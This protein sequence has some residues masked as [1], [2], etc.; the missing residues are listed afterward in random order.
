[1]LSAIGVGHR[2]RSIVL[3]IL[4]LVLGAI[5]LSSQRQSEPHVEYGHIDLVRARKS[6]TNP[7]YQKWASSDRLSKTILENCVLYFNEFQSTK[8]NIPTFHDLLSHRF[9]PLIFKKAKWIAEEKK[10]YRRVLRDKGIQ[11]DESHM[12]VL[13][14]RFNEETN[15]LSQFEQAFAENSASL[16]LFGKCYLTENTN[17]DDRSCTHIT[18][19][20]LPAF[21]GKLP[22]IESWESNVVKEDVAKQCVVKIIKDKMKGKGIV[23]P[24]LPSEDAGKETQL[25]ARLIHVLRALQNSLPIEIIYVEKGEISKGRKDLLINAARSLTLK[26]PSSLKKYLEAYDY[27]QTLEL[28]QQDIRFINLRPAISKNVPLTDSLA[29]VLSTLFNSFEEMILLSPHT[30]PLLENLELLFNNVDYIKSGT[31]FFK[32]RSLLTYKP[33][34]FPNGFFEVNSLVNDYGGPQVSDLKYFQL[35]KPNQL[36]TNWIREFGFTKLLDPSMVVINKK[37]ALPGLIL[38]STLPFYNFLQP[39]YD[40]SKDLNPEILWLGIEMA[41]GNVHFNKNSAAIAGVLTPPE[42]TPAGRM[43]R[44]LCSS[45]WA[46]IY[47]EN[48]FSMVYITSHQLE[49]RVLPD[50]AAAVYEK[51]T[52]N[53]KK[54]PSQKNKESNTEEGRSFDD[55]LVLQTVKRNLLYIETALQPVAIE[56]PE[57]KDNDE[58]SSPWSHFEGFGSSDDY[59]CAYDIVGS[60]DLTSR[61]L[62]IN[63]N[64]KIVSRHLFLLDVWQQTPQLYHRQAAAG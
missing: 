47:E 20:L 12:Q 61:G 30:I 55:P 44:E 49:N 9:N 52:P 48:D 60:I 32:H 43:S 36:T 54:E 1:M 11:L 21:S 16:R 29:W 59:W 64:D 17:L 34:K 33:Y 5:V 62:L 57:V 10:H 40:F 31:F 13:N 37:K 2:L 35:P 28:P 18:S 38:A 15:R 51:L 58:P 27:P 39:K 4:L 41:A 23:I 46:Q 53:L 8:S 42:N 7:I 22:S 19:R 56:K 14:N 24:L 26:M 45:S 63:Y 50:F 3:T 6:F 25:V